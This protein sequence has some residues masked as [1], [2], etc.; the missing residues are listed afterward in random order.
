M[1][2]EAEVTHAGTAERD[3][4]IVTAGGRVLNVTALGEDVRCRPGRRVCCRRRDRV[5][6]QDLSPGH[7]RHERT[8]RPQADVEAEL[9]DRAR[10]RGPLVGIV[11]GSKSDM[12][13]MQK[14]ARELE[15]R[16]ILHEVRV[17]S[18]HREPEMVADYARTRSCAASR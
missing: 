16:E 18:A 6:R 2:A 8:A 12:E 14:A 7:R 11:M 13:K 3:G 1:P 15:Q 4:A 5:R 9:A 10:G 17:M